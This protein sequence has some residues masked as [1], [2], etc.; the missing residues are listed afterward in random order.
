MMQQLTFGER[1]SM[2]GSIYENVA[3]K[4]DGVWKFR[5]LH[6]YNTW[7]AGYDGGWAHDP[8][9]GV[10]GPSE[11]YP[12]DGPPTLEFTMFPNVYHIP[13]HYLHPVTGH[14]VPGLIRRAAP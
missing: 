6:T 13:Y 7:T 3:V 4:E 12:P 14:P 9:R 11:A 8:G 5:I 10:P 2:G 1:A